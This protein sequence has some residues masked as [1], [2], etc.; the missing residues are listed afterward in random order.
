MAIQDLT[1][2][3]DL[4]QNLNV[5]APCKQFDSLNLILSIYD[6][7]LQADLSNYDVRLRAMKADKVPLIQEHIGITIN[8]NIVNI[9]ADEQLTT[10]A[11]KTPIE[12]QFI[13]KSTGKKKATFN[14]VL[15]VVPSTVNI[16]GTISTA[17][18]TLL[19]ELENKLDQASDFFENIDSAITAN[20]NLIASTDTANSTKQALDSSNTTALATKEALDTSNTNATTTKNELD[21]LNTT[22]INTKNDLDTTNVTGQSLLN[23]LETFEQ[24]HADV[25]DISNQLANINA[26]LSENVQQINNLSINKADKTEINNL[27]SEKANQIDLDTEI[28]NRTNAVS[29][30]KIERQA[31]IAVERARINSFTAL[32]AGST[33][34]D[35]ELIDLRVGEDGKTYNNAGSAVREQLSK[36]NSTLTD[37]NNAVKF[38]YEQLTWVAGIAY[39]NV[40]DSIVLSNT[41]TAWRNATLTNNNYKSMSVVLAYSSSNAYVLFLDANDKVINRYITTSGDNLIRKNLVIP[42]G[43][44]KIILNFYSTNSNYFGNAIFYKDNTFKNIEESL[45]SVQKSN[46]ITSYKETDL[47]WKAGIIKMSSAGNDPN[48][49]DTSTTWR[50]AIIDVPNNAITIDT[51]LLHSTSNAE[52]V[53]F[54]ENTKCKSNYVVKLTDSGI[55]KTFN[56][57]LNTKKIGI[58]YYPNDNYS[59]GAIVFSD[60]S[61]EKL[62][63]IDSRMTVQEEAMTTQKEAMTMQ[64]YAEV[65]RHLSALNHVFFYGQS[66]SVGARGGLPVTVDCPYPNNMYCWDGYLIGDERESANNNTF[67]S[68]VNTNEHTYNVNGET[69]CSGWGE[70]FI[71]EMKKCNDNFYNKFI[72]S[73]PGTGGVG[74][75][76]L[77]RGSNYYSRLLAE[78]TATKSYA[79]SIGQTYKVLCINWVQGEAN[80]GMTD[81]LDQMLLLFNN[82]NVDIKAITGQ[83][84]DVY[85]TTYQCGE[86]GGRAVS[87]AQLDASVKYPYKHIYMSSPIYDGVFNDEVHMTSESYKKL[88][89]KA[90]NALF[91]VLKGNEEYRPIYPKSTTIYNDTNTHYVD[92]IFDVPKKPLKVNVFYYYVR[93]DMAEVQEGT[94]YAYKTVKGSAINPFATLGFNLHDVATNAVKTVSA[95]IISDDTVR[96]Y[97]NSTINNGDIIRYASIDN[98]NNGLYSGSGAHPNKQY[99]N[100]CDSAGDEIYFYN[101]NEKIECNNLLPSFVYTIS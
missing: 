31:E 37:I 93:E 76:E 94:G 17:T 27:A 42:K 87:F 47:T 21:A 63:T 64:E 32:A 10:T 79:D 98:S 20:N 49:V 57:P 85:F 100:I 80:G 41:T 36:L 59:F 91:N 4:K 67:T 78:V 61:H 38:S 2:S 66:L 26:D 16:N 34:G 30:E 73:C 11:G 99:G 40:G 24:E 55:R 18:Y 53:Y 88:G 81:Y 86:A 71:K 33:T 25:T 15:V 60:T 46:G 51:L 50:Y 77:G 3:L 62:K 68:L 1:A 6:N 54:D 22:A 83:E 29:N 45:E 101:G 74:I 82:L 9:E 70:Y 12:I 95:S 84:E 58:S 90:G 75:L 8:S 43:T 65:K 23:S 56:I 96:I 89:Y 28:S 48:V 19:E 69:S 35:A 92:V 7:S 52:I 13:N 44:V 72:F 97:A 39:A 14:L 5:F